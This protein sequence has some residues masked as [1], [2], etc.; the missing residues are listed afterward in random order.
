MDILPHIITKK[1]FFAGSQPNRAMKRL[2]RRE[3]RKEDVVMSETEN[4]IQSPNDVVKCLSTCDASVEIQFRKSFAEATGHE[5][6]LTESCGWLVNLNQ[7]CPICRKTRFDNRRLDGKRCL[8][9]LCKRPLVEPLD[10]Q[11]NVR[12]NDA[13]HKC[14]QCES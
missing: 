4:L 7:A 2:I 3:R 9:R 14:G 8:C 5:L 11:T 10:P 12:C 6:P 13:S 1:L